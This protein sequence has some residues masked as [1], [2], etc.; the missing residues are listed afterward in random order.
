LDIGVFGGTFN[1][2]HLGH[3]RAAEEVREALGLGRVVFV[4]ARIPPHKTPSEV[5]PPAR[6]LE[7]VRRAIGEN[8]F[9]EVSDLE[10]RREGPSYSVD[11]LST[12]RET[13]GSGDRLFFLMGAD[14][15]R[16]VH[17]WHR[18]REIFRLAD[19]VVMRRPPDD[20]E[21]ALPA[22]LE[23]EFVPCGTGFRHLSGREV[24]FVPVTLLDI[25]ST[26]VRRELAA[27]RSVR[28]LVP[29]AVLPCLR[30]RSSDP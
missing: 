8:P 9:F 29:D 30:E 4:P 3:L 12:L 26:Q 10:L 17:T 1:P 21:V 13:L 20:R 18:F 25:S 2:V 14:A 22:D 16:E 27:G 5:A 6:R 19:V 28:Y 23:H 15:F 7:L 24:K 11:T